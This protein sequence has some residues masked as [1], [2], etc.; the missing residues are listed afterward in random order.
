MGTRGSWVAGASLA[1]AVAGVVRVDGVLLSLALVGVL[2]LGVSWLLGRANL[3][4]LEM[5]Y[6]GPRAVTAESA[7][8]ARIGVRNGRSWLDGFRLEM[9]VEG[10]SG[11]TAAAAVPWVPAGGKSEGEVV[12]E[13]PGR[14][15]AGL[16]TMLESDYPW[17]LFHFASRREIP[18]EVIVLP[19]VIPP[20]PE[21]YGRAELGELAVPRSV[22]R[23]SPGDWR[24]LRGYLPGDRAKSVSW[25]ASVR[26]VARGGGLLVIEPEPPSDQLREVTLL[27][28]SHGG[29][30]L[31]RPD[32]F[33]RALSLLRGE[34]L[35]LVGLG[36]PVVWVADFLE[37]VPVRIEG[38]KDL[39]K[40]G[41]LLARARRSAGTQ[42]HEV[43][44]RLAD[45]KGAVRVFSDQPMGEWRDLV[46]M[47]DGVGAVD[48]TDYEGRKGGRR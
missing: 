32:R 6:D 48:V 36:L 38:R 47:R 5:N 16:T 12:L 34:T 18:R 1:L 23:E 39:A 44:G 29:G 42:R 28:H 25:P 10:P 9:R 45:T 40:A 3:S 31:I 24:G 37:W 14:G 35:R 33:E 22:T 11:M 4:L 8:R 15:A 20:L 27:F 43:A 17:G 13:L 46:G 21:S 30:G 19:R 7:A 2:L 26:S 41:E